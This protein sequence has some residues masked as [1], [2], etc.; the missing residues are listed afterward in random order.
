MR[1]TYAFN[2]FLAVASGWGLVCFLVQVGHSFAAAHIGKRKASGVLLAAVAS[3]FVLLGALG[4]L[5]RWEIESSVEL[6]ARAGAGL[7][8]LIGVA[9]MVVAVEMILRSR[10]RDR[11]MRK[12]ASH[13]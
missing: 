5:R 9:L 2:V 6:I 10:G 4:L 11:H 3:P 7:S 8:V 13:G 12:V 1:S